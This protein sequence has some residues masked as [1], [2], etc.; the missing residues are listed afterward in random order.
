MKA[1][2]KYFVPVI[3]LFVVLTALFI[4]GRTALDRWQVDQ[5][6]LLVG[7]ILLF[8]ITLVSFLLTQRGI[9]HSNPNVFVRAIYSSVMIKLFVCMIA[10]FGYISLH[11]QALNK[12]ALFTCMAL[13]LVYT[14]MEV[15]V[16]MKMLKAK[17]HA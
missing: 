15:G 6:V 8:L 10:A 1:K 14:F 12:P 13:Y 11:K 16:L 5:S 17:S 4:S 7:N 3:L 2:L 9:A